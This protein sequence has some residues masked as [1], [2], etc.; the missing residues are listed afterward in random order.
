MLFMS[1][2]M[3][4]KVAMYESGLMCMSDTVKAYLYELNLCQYSTLI[5]I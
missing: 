5:I 3:Y 1:T 2:Y 4:I